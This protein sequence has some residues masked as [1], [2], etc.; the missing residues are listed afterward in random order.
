MRASAGSAENMKMIGQIFLSQSLFKGN[1]PSSVLSPSKSLMTVHFVKGS[2]MD[3]EDVIRV[4]THQEKK[5]IKESAQG[6]RE[7]DPS[8]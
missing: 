6:L 4:F 2:F 1:L 3:L 7:Q 8:R 5:R